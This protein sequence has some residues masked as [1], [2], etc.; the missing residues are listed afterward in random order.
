MSAKAK[1]AKDDTKPKAKPK[2]TKGSGSLYQRG[3]IWWIYYKHPDG[4]RIAESTHTERRAVAEGLLRKRV[5]ARENNLA[6]IKNAEQL[7]VHD[8]AKMV[9]NDCTANGRRSNQLTRRLDKHLLPFFGGRRLIG[10]TTADVTAFVAHRQAQGIVAIRGPHKGKRISDV[11]N[12]EINRELQVLKRMFSLAIDSGRIATKPK[13]MMLEESA[14]RSGFFEPE[15]LASVLKHL[16]A[17]I[18]PVIEFAATTGWRIT[19]EVLPLE[20]RRVDFQAGEVRL[21]PGMTKNGKGRTFPMTADLRALLETQQ[22]AHAALKKAGHLTPYVFWRMVAKGRGGEKKPRA[23]TAFS[24]AW[25]AACRTAGCPGRIPHDLR[26]TAVRSFVRAGLS[27]HVAMKLSGHLTPSV[28]R[29]YD[30]VSDRDLRDA[31]RTLDA[32]STQTGTR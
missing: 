24:G 19:S 21:D 4:R 11:S 1:P 13:I 2:Q 27:E 10:I 9:L 25:K 30:I 31:M 26:R 16:P 20:W 15:Q 17:E 32:A 8:A 29:R 7:T 5:G 14:P 18:R 28:F 22:A 23:I 6:V 12:A 3:R